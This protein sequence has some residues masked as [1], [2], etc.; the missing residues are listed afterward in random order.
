MFVVREGDGRV[1]GAVINGDGKVVRD[2]THL[3]LDC[4]YTGLHLCYNFR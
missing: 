2:G 4:G 1:V 3:Y